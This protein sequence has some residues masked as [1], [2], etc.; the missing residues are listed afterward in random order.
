MKNKETQSLIQKWIKIYKIEKDE[1]LIEIWEQEFKDKG[2]PRRREDQARRD[3]IFTLIG[4]RNTMPPHTK[5]KWKIQ[6]SE[7]YISVVGDNDFYILDVIKDSENIHK[8][9][10]QRIVK[11]VNIHDE[12]VEGIESAIFCLDV[13][14]GVAAYSSEIQKLENILKR[15]K[16]K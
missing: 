15:A 9:N 11:A 4:D 5:G 10:A 13:A 7:K 8:A 12:L 16:Q 6:E 2:T 3:A 14:N 1:H